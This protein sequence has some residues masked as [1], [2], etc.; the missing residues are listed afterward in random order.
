MVTRLNDPRMTDGAYR[1][2]D[3]ADCLAPDA[4]ALVARFVPGPAFEAATHLDA[5]RAHGQRTVARV[6]ALQ[7]T[8]TSRDATRAVVAV[9]AVSVVGTRQLGHVVAGWSTDTLTLTL[10]GGR[11]L[12]SAY[13]SAPGPVPVTAQPPDPIA[14]AFAVLAGSTGTGG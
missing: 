4:G 14:T 5:D 8:V 1:A 10:T 3:A 2:A 11:W 13:T 7:A 6:V 9:W 12:L